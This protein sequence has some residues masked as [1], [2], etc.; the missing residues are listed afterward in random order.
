MASPQLEDGY[1]KV[2]NEL[3]EALVSVQMSG[4][5][6]Q[7]L[8]C[9][10]RKSYGYNQKEAWLKNTYVAKACGLHRQRVYEAKTRLLEKNIVTQKRDKIILNKD[11]ETWKVSRKNVTLV[12]EK[13]YKVSRKS[14]PIKENKE[15]ILNKAAKAESMNWKKYNED[16]HY[17]DNAIDLETGEPL[18]P[19]GKEKKKTRAVDADV[20]AVF[21][22]FNNPARAL[23]RLREIERVAAQT[24]FEVYGLETLKKRIARIE[25]EK[26]KKDPYFPE[27]NTPSQLL[28][29]M[30]SVERYLGI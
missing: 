18:L 24:L 6:W 23:W 30:S 19:R 10:I 14:V 13:R 20:L 26:K 4:S 9:L 21:E 8:M 11:Y 25:I 7:Y 1:T 15:T 5:E 22:L 17:E 3:L 2:A 12:T 29:K 28:D 16:S 27:V